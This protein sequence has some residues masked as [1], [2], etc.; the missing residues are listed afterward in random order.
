MNRYS[1][2]AIITVTTIFSLISLLHFY[3]ASGGQLWYSEV[4]PT[5]SLNTQR[6]NPSPTAALIVAFGM[7]LMAVVVI[8]C[9]GVFD[10]YLNR[11]YFRYGTLLIS[12][13]FLLRAI[14]DFRFVGFFKTVTETRFG[15]NDTLFF[16][17]LCLLI[18][19]LTVFV[20]MTSRGPRSDLTH[21]SNTPLKPLTS[22]LRPRKTTFLH[23]TSP[24]QDTPF[25]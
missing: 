24:L 17:P 7:L 14:G 23:P 2:N 12:L 18:S 16:S 25:P 5:N 3:W 20:F 8:G 22:D 19:G 10:K 9:Q 15:I 11:K 6:L 21:H 1:T 13:I 4:L